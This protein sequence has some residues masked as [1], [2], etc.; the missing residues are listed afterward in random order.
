VDV[1]LDNEVPLKFGSH[2]D[3]KPRTG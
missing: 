1:A 3:P 2:S